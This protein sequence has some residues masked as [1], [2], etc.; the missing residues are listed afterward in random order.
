MLRK[1]LRLLPVVTMVTGLLEGTELTGF[2]TDHYNV[3]LKLLYC[4]VRADDSGA[5]DD[6]I[7]LVTM[8]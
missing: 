8:L 2:V 6:V 3:F 1:K 7:V 4:L 5:G